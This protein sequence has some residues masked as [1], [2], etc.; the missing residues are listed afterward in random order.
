MDIE[1]RLQ[2]M[3]NDLKIEREMNRTLR[4][5]LQRIHQLEEKINQLQ[6]IEN[7]CNQNNEII[8]LFQLQNKEL[9]QIKNHYQDT[10]ELFTKYK[11]QFIID[12][13]HTYQVS[14]RIDFFYFTHIKYNGFIR[15]ETPLFPEHFF[16]TNRKFIYKISKT[17]VETPSCFWENKIT[18]ISNQYKTEYYAKLYQ[19]SSTYGY[20]RMGKY[21]FIMGNEIENNKNDM[22]IEC[23]FTKK[24]FCFPYDKWI[25]Y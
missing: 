21:F 19:V 8:T 1:S 10:D 13:Q 17:S 20:I 23:I 2:K 5:Q 16:L 6:K 24:R 14:F 3:E 18:Y 22:I 9:L 12:N 15:I 7:L 4:I 11:N 25:L